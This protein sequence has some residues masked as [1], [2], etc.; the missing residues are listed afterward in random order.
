MKDSLAELRMELRRQDARR[1]YAWA[2][3]WL[4]TYLAACAVFGFAIG[5]FG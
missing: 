1:R 5:V 4:A 3:W 2:Y